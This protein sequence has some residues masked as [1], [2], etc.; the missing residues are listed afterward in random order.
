MHLDTDIL[1]DLV[2]GRLEKAAQEEWLQHTNNCPAC[3]TELQSCQ[4][5]SLALRRSHLH[6]ATDAL[7]ERAHAMFERPAQ[8]A[9]NPA[10]SSLRQILA[11]LV[12]DS[13]TQ[14]AFAG[15]RGQAAARQVVMRAEEFDIHVR[16]WA[17]NENRQV[18]GQIQPRGTNTFIDTARLHLLQNGERVSSASVNELGEFHFDFVPAGLLSLQIDLPHLT[19]IG[20]LDVSEKN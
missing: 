1:I 13:F 8:A 7:L 17:T 16:I 11:S 12:F 9:G 6:S 15:A 18:L 5:L 10:K 20:S 4:K 19:V 14:P 3:A 2:D